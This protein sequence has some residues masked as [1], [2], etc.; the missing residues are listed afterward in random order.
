MCQLKIKLFLRSKA[1]LIYL[2]ET[3]LTYG[4]KCKGSKWEAGNL[5]LGHPVLP[6]AS[7]VN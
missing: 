4:I 1:L 6:Q 3:I 5:F 2:E 7:S